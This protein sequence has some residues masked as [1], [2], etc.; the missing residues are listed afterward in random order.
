MSTA[1]P[2]TTLTF[3]SNLPNLEIGRKI[4]FIGCVTAYKTE[5]G[6]LRLQHSYPS[7][8]SRTIVALVDVNLV[9]ENSKREDLEIGS[10]VNVIGYVEKTTKEKEAAHNT[11]DERERKLNSDPNRNRMID[12]ISVQAVMLWN[13]GALKITEYEKALE[14]RLRPSGAKT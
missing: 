9:L 14:Q 6:V 11:S 8:Q 1:P 5:S 3:L 2:A 12:E 7:S 13:A 10:W 4:R